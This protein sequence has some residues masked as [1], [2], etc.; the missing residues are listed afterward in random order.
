M[1]ALLENICIGGVVIGG[2][3]SYLINFTTV[4]DFPLIGIKRSVDECPICLDSLNHGRVVKMLCPSGKHMIHS[5]CILE[6]LN[7]SPTC[8]CCR[9]DFSHL[10]SNFKECTTFSILLT[11]KIAGINLEKQDVEVFSPLILASYNR[12]YEVVKA[13]LELNVNINMVDSD[14]ERNALHWNLCVLD[15][16]YNEDL[17]TNFK[18]TKL[19]LAKGADT[20]K[21]DL[22][23]DFP[24]HMAVQNDLGIEVIKLLV[25]YGALIDLRNRTGYTP[26]FKAC[27]LKK[28]NLLSELVNFGANINKKC[29][30]GITPIIKACRMLDLILV[31]KLIE[32]GADLNITDFF[33]QTP[34]HIVLLVEPRNTDEENKISEIVEELVKN[35]ADKT[36][37]DNAGFLPVDIAIHNDQKRFIQ[38]LSLNYKSIRSKCINCYIFFE[39]F[40]MEFRI[41][42]CCL[43]FPV[44]SN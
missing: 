28:Y 27:C 6:W 15:Q 18:I 10:L 24:L 33:G 29:K 9:H 19:L 20:N 14:D 35:G 17:E 41:L 21:P 38:K 8:P 12:Q 40:W 13:L 3:G 2:M 5:H 37:K 34:L 16:D 39:R 7:L 25:D 32:L 1:E 42:S 26:F 30:Y 22:H 31:K 43:D 11:M 36:I 44:K 23:G 4:Q